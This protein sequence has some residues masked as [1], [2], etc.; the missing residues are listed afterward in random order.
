MYVKAVTHFWKWIESI[1]TT[2]ERFQ[3]ASPYV[4]FKGSL[5]KCYFWWWRKKVIACLCWQNLLWKW[6]VNLLLPTGRNSYPVGACL[7]QWY[8]VLSDGINFFYKE[9][10]RS[11]LHLHYRWSL[12]QGGDTEYTDAQRPWRAMQCRFIHNLMQSTAK[13]VNLLSLIVVS[14]TWRNGRSAFQHTVC[15]IG[16]LPK[17]AGILSVLHLY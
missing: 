8:W 13:L 16:C 14:W 17:E 10:K 5:L 9:K 6:K 12:S 3:R 15:P 2:E 11:K 1:S 4:S 7:L